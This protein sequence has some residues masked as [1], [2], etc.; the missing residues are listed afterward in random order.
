MLKVISIGYNS[1]IVLKEGAIDDSA[2]SIG[3]TIST[4]ALLDFYNIIITVFVSIFF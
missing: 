2:D 4:L 1:C 3:G